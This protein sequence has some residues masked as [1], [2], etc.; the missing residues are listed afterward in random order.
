MYV[1]KKTTLHNSQSGT[2]VVTGTILPVAGA[3]TVGLQVTGTFV[4]DVGFKASVDESNYVAVQGVNRTTGVVGTAAASAGLYTIPVSGMQMFQAPVLLTSGTVTATA[5]TF[6]GESNYPQVPIA[7]TVNLGDVDILSIAAGETHI[8]AFGGH[9]KV[10]S[11]TPTIT[12]GTYHAN[13]VIGGTMT[14]TGALRATGAGGLL[15][16]ILVLD[17][18]NQKAPLEVMIFNTTLA[19]TFTDN[20]QPT[21]GTADHASLIRRIS[22]TAGDWTTINAAGTIAIAD[23]SPG[24]RTLSSAGT[25]LYAVAW[26]SGT[27]VYASTS[28]LQ[29]RFGILQD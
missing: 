14:L 5:V 23:V 10:I 16:S 3:N 4:G 7:S 28:D 17:K 24:A 2:A 13:D 6:S 8:G 1:E 15:S 27:P 9:T 22:V 18:G 20:V 21:F 11:I 25:T 26:T 29:F 12:A 19:G